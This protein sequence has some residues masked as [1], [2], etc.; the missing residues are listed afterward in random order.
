MRADSHRCSSSSFVEL[1]EP[2]GLIASVASQETICGSYKAPWLLR[3]PPGQTIYITLL[4]YSVVPLDVTASAPSGAMCVAYASIREKGGA[5]P[6]TLCGGREQE[7]IVYRSTTNV[8]EII[9]QGAGKQ[10]FF[11]L[12]YQCEYTCTGQLGLFRWGRN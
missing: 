4:D 10:R 11:L 12:K 1:T 7:K 3:A 8:V 5:R 9:V 6:V 2:T